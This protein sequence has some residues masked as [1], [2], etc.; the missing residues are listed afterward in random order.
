[1]D[2]FKG[3]GLT[4]EKHHSVLK[5]CSKLSDQEYHDANERIVCETVY[6]VNGLPIKTVSELKY[7]G[8][9]ALNNDDSKLPSGKTGNVNS[10]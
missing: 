1:M 3:T 6:L 9:S 4:H 2:C 5:I 7:L 8:R 10:L